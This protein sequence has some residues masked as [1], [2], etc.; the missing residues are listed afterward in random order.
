MNDEEILTALRARISLN[1]HLVASED[2]KGFTSTEPYFLKFGDQDMP[3][4]NFN[5][6]GTAEEIMKRMKMSVANIL[7]F[8]LSSKHNLSTDQQITLYEYLKNL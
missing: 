3:V 2:D 4:Q 7:S 1:T 6:I 8:A 5:S